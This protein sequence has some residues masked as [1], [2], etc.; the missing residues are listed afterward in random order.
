MIPP[1]VGIAF[2]RL[3]HHENRGGE[4]QALEQRPGVIKDAGVGVVERDGR[5]AAQ[6]FP[7]GQAVHQTLQWDDGVVGRE[8]LHLPRECGERHVQAE[9]TPDAGVGIGDD[10]VVTENEAPAAQ[11]SSDLRHSGE[12]QRGVAQGCQPQEGSLVRSPA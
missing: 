4:V 12:L 5:G 8:P 3:R 11:P 7:G 9:A 10:V 6:R 1:E 2:G